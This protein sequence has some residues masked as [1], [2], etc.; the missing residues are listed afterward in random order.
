MDD[1]I[2]KQNEIKAVDIACIF[3]ISDFEFY[4]EYYNKIWTG[5]VT[6]I[7]DLCRDFSDEP[8]RD[9]SSFDML[10]GKVYT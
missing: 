10:W 1:E 6:D 9:S 5:L 7:L 2:K 8:S 4:K 3:K